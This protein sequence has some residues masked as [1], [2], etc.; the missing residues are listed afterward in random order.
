MTTS[1]SSGPKARKCEDRPGRR[2]GRGR[3]GRDHRRPP[4]QRR[5]SGCCSS[6]SSPRT[7][8]GLAGPAVAPS[9]SRRR[10]PG[11]AE[12]APRSTWP[13]TSPASRWATSRTTWPAS[14]DCD[15]VIEVVVENMAVKKAAARREGRPAPARR[16]PSSPPTPPASRSTRSPTRCPRRCA[17]ASWSPT[18]STRRATCGCSRSSRAASPIP[19]VAAGMAAFIAAAARQGDRPRQGHAQ[20]RGQPHRRLRHVQRHPPHAWSWA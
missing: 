13:P 16:T 11:E 15:W 2:A 4:G 19:A 7:G 8:G 10:R 14:R 5:A 3:H 6:T 18:S 9:G 12:A 17:R 1:E 20:L